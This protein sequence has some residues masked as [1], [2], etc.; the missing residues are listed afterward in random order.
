MIVGLQECSDLLEQEQNKCLTVVGENARVEQLC[1]RPC[2][3][4]SFSAEALPSPLW[5][6]AD[7]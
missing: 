5:F 2:N 6:D 1:Y 3:T 7:L 4:Q